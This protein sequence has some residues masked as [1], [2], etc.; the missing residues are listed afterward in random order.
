MADLTTSESSAVNEATL[1]A[2]DALDVPSEW[3]HL[4]K[5]AATSGV[6]MTVDRIIRI[7]QI[8]QNRPIA[9]LEKRVLWVEDNLPSAGYQ[10]MLQHA[11]EFEQIGITKD[12]LAEIA[13]AATTI[14]IPGGVQGQKK[15]RIGRPI[16]GLFFY[17]KPLAVAVSVGSNG[18]VVGMNRAS[19]VEFQKKTGLTDDRINELASWPTGGQ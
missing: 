8:D 5:I 18:F 9:G 12:Q 11:H 2:I 13:E 4:I 3:K 6:L 17:G 19:W 14:G 15:K 10:H 16:F 7:W 1:A